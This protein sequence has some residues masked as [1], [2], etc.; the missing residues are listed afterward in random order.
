MQR[1][2]QQLRF[3]ISKKKKKNPSLNLKKRKRELRWEN[4][5]SN[6]ITWYL[7]GLY[8]GDEEITNNIILVTPQFILKKKQ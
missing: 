6:L 4:T 5:T 2:T 8:Y 1:I 3:E 7:F